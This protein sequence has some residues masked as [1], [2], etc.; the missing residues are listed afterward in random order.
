LG[1]ELYTAGQ[2]G[3]GGLDDKFKEMLASYLDATTDFEHL[4]PNPTST[5]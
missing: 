2:I 1:A 5:L 3:E 4:L